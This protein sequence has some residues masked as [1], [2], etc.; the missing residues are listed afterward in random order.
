L[1]RKYHVVDPPCCDAP[2][3][4][5]RLLA[6]WDTVLDPGLHTLTR[7]SPDARRRVDFR[8]SRADNLTRACRGQNCKFQRGRR[9]TLARAEVGQKRTYFGVGK[10]RMVL[11]FSH[12]VHGWEGFFKMTLPPRGVLSNA[13]AAYFRKIQHSLDAPT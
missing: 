4:H 5:Q 12:F 10:R 9:R 13:I 8:P 11:D 2:Q 6:Q 3:C 7:D 1:A